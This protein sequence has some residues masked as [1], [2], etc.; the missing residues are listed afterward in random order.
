[1]SIDKEKTCTCITNIH[2]TL[3]SPDSC[4]CIICGQVIQIKHFPS[5][6]IIVGRCS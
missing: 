3:C 2:N 1:M 4:M 5:T 6:K